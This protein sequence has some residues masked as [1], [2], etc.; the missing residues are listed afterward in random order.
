MKKPLNSLAE[1][2]AVLCCRVV[3]RQNLNNCDIQTT[4]NV[5][6]YLFYLNFN[7][8]TKPIH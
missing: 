6:I 5:F 4:I 8:G 7:S 1:I 2:Y 3:S